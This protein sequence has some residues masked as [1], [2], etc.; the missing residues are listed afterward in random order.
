MH[1]PVPGAGAELELPLTRVEGQLTQLCTALRLNDPQALEAAAS[2]LHRA[3]AAAIDHFRHAARS[4]GV[5]APL[6][7]RL[8]SATAQVAA[9]RESLARAT[10]AL[11]RAIDV[12]IPG[13]PPTYSAAGAAARAQ[14]S[15]S[16]RA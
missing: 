13:A 7:Q 14:S 12:L 11:D 15:G 10:A 16:L 2:E 1:N 4:G 9:Q 5:P 6:R 3:L 8:A